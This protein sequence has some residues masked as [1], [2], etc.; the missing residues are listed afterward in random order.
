MSWLLDHNGRRALAFFALLGCCGIMTG[1]AAVSLYLVKNDVK[2]VFYLGLAAHA[3]ILVATT[4]FMALFVKRTISV[5]KDGVSITDN[6]NVD[7]T[8]NQGDK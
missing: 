2:Y 8:V 4:G 3:Q 5:G 1:F 7:V 6:S